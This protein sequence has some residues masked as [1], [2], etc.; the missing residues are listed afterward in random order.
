MVEVGDK[1]ESAREAV[2]TARVEMKPETAE[3]IASGGIGKGDVLAT[4]R[5]AGIQ[6]IKRTSELIPL[7]HPI[8][9]TGVE[10]V[11]DVQLAEPAGVAIEARVRAVDRTGAEMEALTSASTAALAIY[12][13]CKAA[14]RGMRITDLQ[15]EFKSGGQ[16]G[17]WT[18]G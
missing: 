14:E 3:L 2:A 1:P 11:F 9:V 16:S 17:T 15:L 7:C 5:I 10:I 18:R 6:A 12:D 8:R 4:A 13:M